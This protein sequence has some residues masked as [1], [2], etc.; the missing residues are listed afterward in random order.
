MKSGFRKTLSTGIAAL[1]MAMV[2]F[3]GAGTASAQEAGSIYAAA[4]LLPAGGNSNPNGPVS[5]ATF[6]LGEAGTTIVTINLRGQQA[7]TRYVSTIRDGACD[8][9]VL[10]TLT[11]VQTDGSGT[12]ESTTVVKAAVEVGRWHVEVRPQDGSGAGSLCGVA[13]QAMVSGPVASPE[14]E[15]P[16]APGMPRTGG[17]ADVLWQ[18]GVVLITALACL[19]AG[20]R[21][22]I[23]NREQ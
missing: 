4:E 8:G 9:A 16:N 22:Q 13:G 6:V 10:Y 18:P 20:R 23:A 12:G 1:A 14:G 17:Q 2:L 3:A 11:D 5:G 15:Q 7:N 21:L 19:I